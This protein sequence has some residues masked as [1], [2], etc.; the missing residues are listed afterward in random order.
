MEEVAAVLQ[1]MQGTRD[2]MRMRYHRDEM[3]VQQM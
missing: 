1:N 3:R 2:E